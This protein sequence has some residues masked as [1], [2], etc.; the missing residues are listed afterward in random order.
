M[1]KNL[2]FGSPTCQPCKALK[3]MLGNLGYEFEYVDCDETPEMA[4]KYG[5]MSTP[6]LIKV[7]ENGETIKRVS[8]QGAA[9]AMAQEDK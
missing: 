2:L 9:F 8:G 5:V 7:D 6:T 1:T 3:G 4:A